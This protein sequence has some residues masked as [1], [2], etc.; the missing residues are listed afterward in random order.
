MLPGDHLSRGQAAVELIVAQ[1]VLF[2]EDELAETFLDVL[3][4]LLFAHVLVHL[5]GR[6]SREFGLDDV[7]FT[8]FLEACIDERGLL[9]T[10]RCFLPRLEGRSRQ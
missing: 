7:L 2:L 8:I 10:R 3:R 1:A 6:G 4:S 9:C 5:V